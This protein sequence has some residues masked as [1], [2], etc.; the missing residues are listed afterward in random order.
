MEWRQAACIAL[1]GAMG[2]GLWACDDFSRSSGAKAPASAIQ[3]KGPPA[4]ADALPTAGPATTPEAPSA[5]MPGADASASVTAPAVVPASADPEAAAI[6]ASAFGAG[7]GPQARRRL[8]IKLEVLLDRAHFSPGVIDGRPGANLKRALAAFQQARG[9]PG[10]GSLDGPTLEALTAADSRPATQDYVITAA[11]EQGPFLGKLPVGFADM[12]KL[13]HLGYVDPAQELAEKFH[14]DQGLLRGLNPKADFSVAGTRIVVVRPGSADLGAPVAR[15]EVDKAANQ[16]RA[17]DAGGKLIAAFPATV[18]STERPAPAGEW[19]VVS[20]TANPNYTYD[21][22]RLTFGPA[23][24]GKLTIAPGP[25]NPV[26][27]TWIALTKPTYGIH[28]SPDPTRVGK[29]ASHGCVRLT[30]WDAAALGRAVKKGT[31]V[32]FLGTENAGPRG[33][34]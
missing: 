28:G 9:L 7:E 10:D 6:E 12:A 4:S 34:R 33:A 32:A 14:M 29:T 8:L 26:G 31:P 25:N 5:A 15:V 16:L 27:S 17:L 24:K 19:A 20:V 11:D 18:G 23:A 1:F 21:P 22:S 2:I 3:A 13:D 30:N